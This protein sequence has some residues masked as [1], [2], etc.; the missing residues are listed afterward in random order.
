MFLGQKK[1]PLQWYDDLVHYSGQQSCQRSIYKSIYIMHDQCAWTL[2]QVLTFTCQV[3]TSPARFQGSNIIFSGLLTVKSC[4]FFFA[5]TV[6]ISKTTVNVS[7]CSTVSLKSKLTVWTQS[8]KLDT[9]A[10]RRSSF[11]TRESRI[12]K[13]SNMQT[14]KEVRGN[15]NSCSRT[16]C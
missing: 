11:E 3:W 13:F 5:N 10:S 7:F 16:K 8:S 2:H 9:R 1:F 6:S 4:V 15:N 12:K 14:R